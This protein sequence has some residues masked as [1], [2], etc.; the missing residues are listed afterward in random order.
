M[1]NMSIVLTRPESRSVI[2]MLQVNQNQ[3]KMDIFIFYIFYSKKLALT[4]GFKELD[5]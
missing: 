2:I 4:A 1:L 3:D 5:C